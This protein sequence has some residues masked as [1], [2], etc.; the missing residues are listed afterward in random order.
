MIKVTVLYPNPEGAQFD[1]D[2]YV[3][4][5]FP[6]IAARVGAALR[7]YGAERGVAGAMAGMPAP[8][9]AIGHLLFDSLESFQ[10]AFGPHLE[11]IVSDIP[12]YTNTQPTV[13]IGEVTL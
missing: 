10:T 5:H 11:E 6:L 2:Y 4:K 1:M 7:G 13:Q 12:N 3:S 8:Y 9:I